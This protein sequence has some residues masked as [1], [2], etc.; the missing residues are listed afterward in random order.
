MMQRL[1]CC[2][3]LI[4]LATEAIWVTIAA[5]SETPA[6]KSIP[7]MSA[8]KAEVAAAENRIRQA[9]ASQ[10]IDSPTRLVVVY[11]TP[12]DRSPAKNHVERIRLITEEACRFY[13]N[14]LTRH[15]FANRKLRVLRNESQQVDV[16]DVVGG[17]QDRDYGKPDG[18]RIRREVI[19]VLR[20]RGIQAEQVTILLFC[21]LMNYDPVNS[22]ISHHSPYYGGGNHLSGTAWQCDSEIL[23][24]RRFRDPTPLRDGEYGRI[25]I[26]KHNS[27]FIGGVIHE[28]GHAISL[29]H[30]RERQDER[31]SHGTALMGSGNRTYAEQLRGESKGTFL[32]Q[33]HAFRLAALPIF[34]DRVP[35]A[36]FDT[37]SLQWSELRVETISRKYIKVAG[38][39]T[40]SVP[41]HAVVA[42]FDPQGGSD[43]D[44][45]T[46][47]AVVD[48]Q[49][50]FSLRSEMLKP[51][52]KGQLRLVA[53]HVD[54]VTSQ[55]SFDYEVNAAG[56]PVVDKVQVRL[57]LEPIVAAID[58]GKLKAAAAMVE[59]LDSTQ[60][61]VV[62]EAGRKLIDRFQTAKPS[63]IESPTTLP[64]S[65]ASVLLTQ[66]K[67]Q[68]A[69][70]GWLRP[71]YDSVPAK[72]SLL[73]VDGEYFVS[74]IYAHAPAT[75]RYALDHRWK[76]FRGGCGIQDGN[77]G[78]VDFEI[79][80]DK[81]RLWTAEGVEQGSLKHFDVDIQNVQELTLVVTDGHNGASGDWG[82]WVEPTVVR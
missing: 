73:C 34:N 17:G 28:L 70:V 32:T 38:T 6:A 22:E 43:Y 3:L 5:R 51:G 52:L 27:I 48:Q 45:T 16:I 37:R 64:D 29:P 7:T 19:P 67:P 59:Q 30:C 35:S 60:D 12:A 66:L 55:R 72:P 79:W 36:V 58:A 25:T 47:T 26:G 71:T 9:V 33:A 61:K 13:Q 62:Q 63:S 39:V 50:H 20:E 24:P 23:D 75:H 4:Q 77:D 69:K 68:E 40:S 1:T 21:N 2:L 18:D 57:G 82:V 65:V 53:C 81:K 76:R 42:Y 10:A 54:G 56:V 80:G 8:S 31:M 11:F 46:A 14:E 44:A 74:G 41:V 15:G 49:G 78:K